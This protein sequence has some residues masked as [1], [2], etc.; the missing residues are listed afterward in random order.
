[1]G[2]LSP[3]RNQDMGVSPDTGDP[4]PDRNRDLRDL[5]DLKAKSHLLANRE[6]IQTSFTKRQVFK[7]CLFFICPESNQ[8][9]IS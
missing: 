3:D 9:G 4:S 6:L 5:R 2:D 7:A 1:M 8:V